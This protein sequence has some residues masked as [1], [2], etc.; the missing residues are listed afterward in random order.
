MLKY[1]DSYLGEWK[2]EERPKIPK[3]IE[4]LLSNFILFACIWS[5]GGII[6]EGSR[7]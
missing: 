7:N 5:C 1:F 2:N 6:E 4:E 3:E